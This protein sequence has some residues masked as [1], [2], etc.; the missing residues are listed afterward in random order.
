M[1]SVTMIFLGNFIFSSIMFNCSIINEILRVNEDEDKRNWLRFL[2]VWSGG[3]K[4]SRKN[5]IDPKLD[6]KVVYIS[7]ISTI[8][9][10]K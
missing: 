2:S 1:C 5:V 3:N 8:A 7:L 6:F 4:S 9:Q 10:F